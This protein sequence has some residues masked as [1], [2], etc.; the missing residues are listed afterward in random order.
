MKTLILLISFS[1][2]CGLIAEDPRPSISK[3]PLIEPN[4]YTFTF[5]ILKNGLIEHE[6]VEFT[7]EQFSAIA[8]S[9]FRARPTARIA[10]MAADGVSFSV[11]E[12]P[13]TTI[14][15]IGFKDWYAFGAS[16]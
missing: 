2:L 16:F 14:K 5:R 7:Q 3:H 4:E 11:D 13:L 6:E 15:E 12:A 10:F 8:K 1:Y 9:L